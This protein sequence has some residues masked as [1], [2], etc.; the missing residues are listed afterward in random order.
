MA[1]M[2]ALGCVV[3]GAE[4]DEGRRKWRYVLFRDQRESSPSDSDEQEFPEAF[5]PAVAVGV[6]TYFVERHR[7]EGAD[8]PGQLNKVFRMGPLAMEY[9]YIYM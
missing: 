1:G 2:G 7:A 9:V 6:V 3:W 8:F 5:Y 4:E